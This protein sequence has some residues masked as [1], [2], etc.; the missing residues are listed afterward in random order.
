MTNPSHGQ[1]VLL[2]TKQDRPGRYTELVGTSPAMSRM[3]LERND[4][5][6][7]WLP[8]TV[9]GWGMSMA[10][11][12]WPYEW[13]KDESEASLEGLKTEVECTREAQIPKT[14]PNLPPRARLPH[15][16]IRHCPSAATH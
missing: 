6:T 5:V 16:V 1:P 7:Q 4:Y 8:A 10:Q 13:S 2:E 15:S 11:V 12:T 3:A 9:S 14:L